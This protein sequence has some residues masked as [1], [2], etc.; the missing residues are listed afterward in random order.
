MEFSVKVSRKGIEKR[1]SFFDILKMIS[2]FFVIFTHVE[3]MRGGED[4]WIPIFPFLIDMAVPIFM[5][6]TGYMTYK[7]YKDWRFSKMYDCKRLTKKLV[8]YIFP[9]LLV[10][11]VE[12][13]VTAILKNGKISVLQILYQ[14]VRGGK[15]PGGYYVPILVQCLVLL[16]VL[17]CIMRKYKNLGLVIC[18]ILNLIFEILKTVLGISVGV[19][20]LISFRYIF[21]LALGM[22]LFQ[23]EKEK[24]STKRIISLAVSFAVGVGYIILF[25]LKLNTHLL[26]FNYW[27][28]VT[29]M[30]G[31]YIFPIIFLFRKLT[32]GFSTKRRI[33]IGEASYHIFLFQKIWF[34]F[35]SDVI[36]VQPVWF[37]LI[38][39]AVCIPVGI[40]FYLLST[41]IEKRLSKFLTRSNLFCRVPNAKK[42]C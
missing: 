7:S 39:T 14:F 37:W 34:L 13:V 32:F 15:G 3:W 12:V 23:I 33:I 10:F 17:V 38:S 11:I 6:I 35:L 30:C 20:R 9:Y 4:E 25:C 29:M 27:Q 40:V 26:I 21:L 22:W 19:Y 42:S 41:P 18:F 8:R 2:I 31:F 24:V 16:P 28:S 5:I 1:D 36:N